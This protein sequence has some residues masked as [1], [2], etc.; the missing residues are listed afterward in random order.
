MKNFKRNFNLFKKEKSTLV[1]FYFLIFTIMMV[2]ISFIPSFYLLSGVRNNFEIEKISFIKSNGTDTTYLVS[3]LN[4]LFYSTNK[5]SSISHLNKYTNTKD[6]SNEYGSNNG[7][8]YNFIY[9]DYEFDSKIVDVLGRSDEFLPLGNGYTLVLTEDG[10][11]YY[12]DNYYN[13]FTIKLTNVK[14]VKSMHKNLLIEKNDNKIY[15][16]N[17]DDFILKETSYSN[18]DDFF[19]ADN[20]SYYILKDNKFYYGNSILYEN[21]I[22][23]ANSGSTV[24]IYDSNDNIYIIDKPNVDNITIGLVNNQYGHIN[25]LYAIGSYGFAFNID[26]NIYCLGECLIDDGFS[27]LKLLDFKCQYFAG[28]KNGNIALKNNKLF[29]YNEENNEFEGMYKNFVIYYVFRYLFIFICCMILMYLLI[30]FNEYNKRYNRYF[31]ASL[32]KEKEWKRN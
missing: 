9:V 1:A 24:A 13:D 27:S 8:L 14:K 12:I 22:K 2:I 28:S 4:H 29:I 15:K 18:V 25:D 11:L 32:N 16:T 30:S 31:N 3:N 21:I 5:E 20:E 23:G 19:F 17:T 7:P 26:N 6:L 10:N